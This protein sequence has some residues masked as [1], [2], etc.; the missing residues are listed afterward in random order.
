MQEQQ[1]EQLQDKLCKLIEILTD[2]S[3]WNFL[4]D[5]ERQRIAEIIQQ[6]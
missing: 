6:A 2:P 4:S 5:K 3:L 1:V